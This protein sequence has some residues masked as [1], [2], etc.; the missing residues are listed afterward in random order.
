VLLFAWHRSVFRL[1][2]IVRRRWLA[3]ACMA[4]DFNVIFWRRWTH[5]HDGGALG[6]LGSRRI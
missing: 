6:S 3:L 2:Q 4:V 5:G 1:T